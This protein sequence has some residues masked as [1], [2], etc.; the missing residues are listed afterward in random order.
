MVREFSADTASGAYWAASSVV[1]FFCQEQRQERVDECRKD[2]HGGGGRRSGREIV[3][4]FCKETR[5][6]GYKTDGARSEVWSGS[7]VRRVKTNKKKRMI[8]DVIS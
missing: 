3:E 8:R 6:G 1:S 5:A 2:G 7:G 4:G